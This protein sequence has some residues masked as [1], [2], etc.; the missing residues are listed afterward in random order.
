MI[1][2]RDTPTHHRRGRKG[3]GS[4]KSRAYRV[5]RIFRGKMAQKQSLQRVPRL[6]GFEKNSYVDTILNEAQLLRQNVLRSRQV[7]QSSMEEQ[8]TNS[9]CQRVFLSVGKQP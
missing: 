6:R 8:A 7:K 1:V 9:F 5:G 2:R 3:N 4:K